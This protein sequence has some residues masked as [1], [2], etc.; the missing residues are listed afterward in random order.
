MNCWMHPTISKSTF[1]WF[2][3]TIETFR[4]SPGSIGN[5][6]PP[7]HSIYLEIQVFHGTVDLMLDDLLF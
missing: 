5:R 6:Q 2:Q 1:G 7:G 4:L 3:A